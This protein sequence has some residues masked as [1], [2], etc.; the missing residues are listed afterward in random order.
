[1]F[2]ARFRRRSMVRRRKGER[3]T[4]QEDAARFKVLK[5]FLGFDFAV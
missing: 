2:V 4:L 1:M 3:E 5:L